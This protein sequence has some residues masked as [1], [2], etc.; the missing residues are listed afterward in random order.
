MNRNKLCTLALFLGFSAAPMG[1]TLQNDY[2]D[3]AAYE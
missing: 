1:K 3:H 2:T